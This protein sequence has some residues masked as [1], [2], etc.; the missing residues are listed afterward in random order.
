[1]SAES[2]VGSKGS[3]F[4]TWAPER[5]MGMSRL[6][7]ADRQLTRVRDGVMRACA[8]PSALHGVM[9]NAAGLAAK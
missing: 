2:F 1:M 4:Y 9:A 8:Q 7:F 6:Q 3:V 5:R